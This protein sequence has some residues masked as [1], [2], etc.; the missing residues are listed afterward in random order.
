MKS[1]DIYLT[2]VG[3]QGIGLLSEII[4]RAGDHAGLAGSGVD[5]HGLAQRGGMV[6]S[7]VRFGAERTTPL[8]R[9]GKADLVIALEVSEALRALYSHARTGGTLVFYDTGWQTLTVRLGQE[10]PP[11]SKVLEEACMQRNVRV[12]GVRKQ[13]LKDFRMQNMVLLGRIARE[14]LI[15]G[16]ERQHYEQA[17]EDLM[18]GP[19]LSANLEIF[20]EMFEQ[21]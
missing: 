21:V 4:I 11:D 7:H 19:M 16:I 6:V 10:D 18:T 12:I 1:F 5:T 13:D 20:R 17:M 2:G 8:V 3:G 14:N 15:P 9:Q